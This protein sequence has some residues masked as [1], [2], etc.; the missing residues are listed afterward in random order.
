MLI[1]WQYLQSQKYFKKASFLSLYTGDLMKIIL[2]ISALA[3]VAFAQPKESQ[4]ISE[5]NGKKSKHAFYAKNVDLEQPNTTNA[6]SINEYLGKLNS[7][8]LSEEK[9]LQFLFDYM[10][11]NKKI[12]LPVGSD[13]FNFMVNNWQKLSDIMGKEQAEFRYILLLDKWRNHALET[14]NKDL[15][16]RINDKLKKFCSKDKIVALEFLNTN[17]GMTIH[18]F[19]ESFDYSLLNFHKANDR[20]NEFK[21]LFAEAKDEV[22]DDPAKIDNIIFGL[23]DVEAEEEELSVYKDWILRSIELDRNYSN[24]MTYGGL[25]FKMEDYKKA[26]KIAKE[27][28]SLIKTAPQNEI[29]VIQKKMDIKYLLEDINTELAKM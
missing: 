21:N 10:F 12:T 13:A 28:R 26:K 19:Q 17:R 24:L 7:E 11:Y 16:I 23:L 5:D 29:K 15:F 1:I 22:W 27:A 14:N 2:L 25:L 9:N 3:F 4:G 20:T 8:E 6:E 18:Y